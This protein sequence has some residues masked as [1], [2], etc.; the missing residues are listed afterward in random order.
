MDLDVSMD[1]VLSLKINASKTYLVAQI[2]YHLDV[3]MVCVLIQI[4]MSVQ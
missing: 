1:H 2:M 4:K 3:Q